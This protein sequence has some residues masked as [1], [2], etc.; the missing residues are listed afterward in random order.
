[1]VRPGS[2]T[3]N[4]RRRLLD[5]ETKETDD[6][7][8]GELSLT[9]SALIVVE[10]RRRHGRRASNEPQRCVFPDARTLESRRKSRARNQGAA[11]R[12]NSDASIRRVRAK[13]ETRM[14]SK[15]NTGAPSEAAVITLSR[16]L[17]WTSRARNPR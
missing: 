5:R 6:G 9:R 17:M 7:P 12:L 16:V 2:A 8:I 15:W 11:R 3:S 14:W 1:M 10:R 13:F 4:K